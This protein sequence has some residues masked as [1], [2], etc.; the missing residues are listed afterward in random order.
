[1]SG[2]TPRQAPARRSAGRNC[3]PAG[4]LTRFPIVDLAPIRVH[5]LGGAVPHPDPWLPTAF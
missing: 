1:M 5:A 2:Q 3:S 4:R